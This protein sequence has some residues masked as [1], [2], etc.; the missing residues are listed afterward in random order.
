M[1]D[2][3]WVRVDYYDGKMTP[4][5][6]KQSDTTTK[7]IRKIKQIWHENDAQQEIIRYACILADTTTIILS[8]KNGLWYI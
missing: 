7:F 4:I 2:N 6:Y 5:S 3:L 1:G 8:Y